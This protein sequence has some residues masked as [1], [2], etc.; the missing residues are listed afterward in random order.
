MSLFADGD[1]LEEDT[2][3][4][5]VEEEQYVRRHNPITRFIHLC[6]QVALL[7]LDFLATHKQLLSHLTSSG[8]AKQL[9]LD[10][11]LV[12]GSVTTVLDQE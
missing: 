11:T 12:N 5:V 3:V 4:E 8:S 2:E 7:E 6:Q 10:I 1:E 9:Q